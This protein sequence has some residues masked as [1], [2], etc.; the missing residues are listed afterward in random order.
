[1]IQ[2]SL[3]P[4]D[5]VNMVVNYV[6]SRTSGYTADMIVEYCISKTAHLDQGD[7]KR[8]ERLVDNTLEELNGSEYIS[9][10]GDWYKTRRSVS[11]A[12]CFIKIEDKVQPMRLTEERVRKLNEIDL[13]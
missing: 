6:N 4:Q 12:E 2:N 8:I 11:F 3:C 1:M 5:Y 9:N 10:R 13:Y 7:E